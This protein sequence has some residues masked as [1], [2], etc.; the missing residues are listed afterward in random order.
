MY[1]Q[2]GNTLLHTIRGE[3]ACQI[4]PFMTILV[5]PGGCAANGISLSRHVIPL[6]TA[7]GINLGKQITVNGKQTLKNSNSSTFLCLANSLQ[8][9]C[10]EDMQ[11]CF[12]KSISLFINHRFANLKLTDI[13]TLPKKYQT[14]IRG[15]RIL[16][17][18]YNR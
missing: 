15:R 12:Q 4:M 5:V 2:L 16:V 7:H 6:R 13:S 11:I 3:T 18:I 17:R 1:C 8:M 10:S 14:F 9:S